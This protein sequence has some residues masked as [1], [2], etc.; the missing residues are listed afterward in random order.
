MHACTIVARNYLAHAR[1]LARSFLE[2]HPG[3]TFHTLVLDPGPGLR[4]GEEPFEAVTPAD[5]FTA[6]EWGP[7]WFAYSV[8]ELAT[9][10][11]PR[12]LAHLLDR[13]GET[14][15]YFD[16]DIRFYRPMAWLERL[17]AEHAVVLTPHTV[18]PVPR[19]ASTPAELF[20]LRSGAHNLGFIS[21]NREARLFLEWWW[22]RLERQCLVAPEK[23]IFV[24]QRWMDFAPSLFDCHLVKDVTVNVAYWNLGPREVTS[25][26][27]GYEVNGEPLTF[28]H[29]SGYDPRRPWLLSKHAGLSPRA[30]LSEKPA[31]RRLCD[32]YAGELFAAGY[33]EVSRYALDQGALP[34]G[35]V[36]DERARRV[37]REAVTPVDPTARQEGVPN[38]LTNPTGL[39]AW[40][41]EPGDPGHPAWLS[42]YLWRLYRDR[43]DLK[44]AFPQ[45]PGADEDR[46]L[47]WVRHHGRPGAGIPEVLLPPEGAE[48]APGFAPSPVAEGV[49]VAG[50]L[51]GELGIGEAARQVAGAVEALGVPLATVTSAPMR[52]RQEHPFAERQPVPGV[53]NPYDV[54]IVCINALR[55][56]RWAKETGPDF[57]S[58][59]YTVGY[60]AWEL[61]E[62]PN[63][64]AA[65]FDVV[66]E[67]WMNSEFAATGVRRHTAKPV[68]VFPVPVRAPAPAAVD[69]RALGLPDGF[70]FLFAFDYGS[71]FERKNPVGL[72]R[73][74]KQAFR[75]GE[76][77]VLVV[78]SINEGSY[79]TKREWLHY[80]AEGRPDIV[81]MEGYVSAGDKDALMAACDCY[82]SLHRSEGFGIT[83]AE[84]MA[85]G[86][87]T[88]ATGYSGNL[89][90]M[91]PQNS[92]LVGWHE[93][94][95]PADCRP[96][97][98]G[99]KWA[100]PD[101]EEA[102]ALLRRV[103]ESPEEARRVG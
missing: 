89:E 74:F 98:E 90:F 64:W 38:P 15:T 70:L 65:A 17:S 27:D 20:I 39:V 97:R 61:E 69:R 67:I 6:E 66:D 84:A 53:V 80:E 21:V 59:R 16:P 5:L 95:V 14:A 62:F 92:Y 86:K 60:W 81:L 23:G 93:G 96:Y 26:E 82:V 45:V 49:N 57:F 68:E 54:N 28:F 50:Y 43:R 44:Q 30:L 73:A 7:L 102:A 75:P 11:K 10:V 72:V 77:P 85:L 36:L 58:N 32:E 88:I 24:D 25:S 48:T 19:D 101:L 42:R 71:V 83:M 46:F 99:A 40:L 76:G 4:E 3:S 34:D 12:L 37:Y 100:E 52:S 79:L 56:G 22:R 51:R 13:F 35:V 33:D 94:R 91:N 47:A 31:L 63:T 29:F 103:Y 2:H 87:P 55:T 1:V 41:R 18:H 9:A 78:K 8:M